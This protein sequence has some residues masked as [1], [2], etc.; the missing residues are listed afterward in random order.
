LNKIPIALGMYTVFEEAK[1]DMPGTFTKLAQMGYDGIEFYGEPAFDI[2]TVRKSLETSGLKLCGWHVEWR[3]LQPQTIAQTIRY[4][5][6]VGCPRAIVP[7]LG[8]KWG[9]AHTPDQDRRAIWEDY[10]IWMN[11]IAARLGENGIQLGYHNHEHE[12]M[13]KYDGERVFD[14]LFQRLEPGIIMELDTG[15]AIEGGADPAEELLKYMGRPVLLHC[16]PYSKQS[17][18]NTVLGAEGDLN[19]WKRILSVCKKDSLALIIES[20]SADGTGFENA[21]ACIE[22]LKRFL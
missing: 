13:L 8:G 9:V 18:F 22:G 7:C 5:K 4:L 17:G 6:A 3:N 10:T 14:I 2:N 12:F 11:G 19:D 21:K 1:A 20:E 15:N 16:K